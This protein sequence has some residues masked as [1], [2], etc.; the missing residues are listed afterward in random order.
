MSLNPAQALK[1]VS[2]MPELYTIRSYLKKKNKEKMIEE[3]TNPEQNNLE[4]ME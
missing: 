2:F 3:A 4:I 1:Q